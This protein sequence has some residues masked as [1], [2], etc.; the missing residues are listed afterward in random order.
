MCITTIRTMDIAT[1]QMM[2]SR[3][4]M[5]IFDSAPVAR[6][7]A[8]M[9]CSRL[10]KFRE[11]T[12]DFEGINWMG[13]GFAHQIFVVFQRNNPNMKLIP[14]NMSEDVEKMYAHVM[15]TTL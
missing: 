10:D 2:I 7:Q 12:I 4:T 14:T 5:I 9:L 1:I 11:V 13:Q 3:V 8:K 6:S 15:K